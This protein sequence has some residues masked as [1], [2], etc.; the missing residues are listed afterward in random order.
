MM[1]YRHICPDSWYG[2][3]LL[4]QVAGPVH[5]EVLD[6]GEEGVDGKVDGNSMQCKVDFAQPR[7]TESKRA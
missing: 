3:S 2:R 7:G 4:C 5:E 6:T 1:Y